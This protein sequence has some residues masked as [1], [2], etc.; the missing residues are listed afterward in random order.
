M[1]RTFKQGRVVLLALLVGAAVV[2]ASRPVRADVITDWNQKVIP[3]VISYSLTAPAYRDMAMIHIAMFDSVNA[4]E[5]RY[6]PYKTKFDVDPTASKD[7]AAAVAAARVLS[8]LH[9]D[10]ATKVES[11][12]ASYLAPAPASAKKS[13]RACGRSARTTARTRRTA[14]VRELRP[15]AMFRRLRWSFPCGGKLR[16]S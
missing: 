14:I 12:L 9:P 3:Y 11:E 10:S 13:R 1:Q 4:I 2:G 8:K 5:P 15:V 7:A 16:R 6:Q